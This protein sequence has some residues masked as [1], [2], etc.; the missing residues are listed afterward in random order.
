MRGAYILV[1]NVSKDISK[2]IGALGKVKFLKGYYAYIGSAMNSIERR[3]GRHLRKEKK[4]FWHIDYLLDDENVKT[5][6][7]FYKESNKK[8]E[9]KIAG[10][11]SKF[12]EPV[13]GFGSSDCNC[14]SHLY[15]IKSPD[16]LERITGLKEF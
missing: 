11:V 5:V 8:E 3:V 6:K 7:V 1:V 13:I 4:K 14:K 2:G 10:M 16:V 9:C 15:K 12:G